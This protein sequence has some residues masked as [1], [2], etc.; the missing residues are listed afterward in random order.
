MPMD[1]C[2]KAL[3]TAAL[4][5]VLLASAAGAQEAPKRAFPDVPESH[6]AFDAV[7]DLAQRGIVRGYP[8]GTFGGSRAVT[9]NEAA[10]GLERFRQAAMKLADDYAKEHDRSRVRG[11]KAPQGDA[12]PRGPRGPQGEPG[13]IGPA[14]PD[15]L[16]VKE[17]EELL[18][19]LGE[20]RKDFDA[21]KDLFVQL[22]DQMRQ[23]R[24]RL[25]AI[26]EEARRAGEQ[27]EGAA[28]S[29]RKKGRS[30]PTPV[31]KAPLGL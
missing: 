11:P 29:L 30:A 23:L 8:D 18:Q 28:G 20:M 3:A 25:R 21:T 14:G 7:Q 19:G 4:G 31:P 1:R 10:V 26:D 16:S 24:A 17:R 12:G 9:R 22:R 15:G 2:S 13:A 27:T 5:V 6:W